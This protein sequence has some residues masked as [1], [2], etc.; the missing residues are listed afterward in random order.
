MEVTE[1]YAAEIEDITEEDCTNFIGNLVIDRTFDGYQSEIQAVHKQLKRLLGVK[2]EPASDE[3]NRRNNVDFFIRVADKYIDIQVKPAGYAYL[4][5]IINEL[6][7][8][9]ETVKN[10]P[11]NIHVMFI[12]S[13]II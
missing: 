1:V 6:R 8:R 5:Q 10:L 2:I 12:T 3:W 11:Q 13:Y 9:K 7:F 4:P